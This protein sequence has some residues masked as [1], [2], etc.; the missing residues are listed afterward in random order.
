MS[1]SSL[2]SA[3]AQASF[4]TTLF[5]LL[6]PTPLLAIDLAGD[7]VQL[8]GFLTQGYMKSVEN[9]FLGDTMD[10]TFRLTEI[11]LNINARLT[12][13]FRLGG[14]AL[15]SHLPEE[16]KG[17]V[18]ADWLVADYHFADPF[19]VR[20]GKLKMPMGLFNMER[21]SDFL[22]PLIFLPQSIYDESLRDSWQAHWGGEMYG[23]L[24]LSKWGDIDYQL[25][26]GRIHY[27]DD[28]LGT[29]TAT[30]FVNRYN[31][32]NSL[33]LSTEDLN[34]ENN[35]V[36]GAALFFNPS[37]KGLRGALTLLALDEES[38][39]NEDQVSSLRVKSKFVASLEYSWKNFCW[40]GE[41]SETDR[42]QE[43]FHVTTVDGPSQAWYM[44]LSYSPLEAL[45]LSLLYDEYYR[46]KSSHHES[47]G[48]QNL[49]PWRKD[50]S[51]SL[52]YDI[53]ENWTFKAE[54]HTVD[55]TALYS[56]YFNPQG[57][58]RFWQYG[59]LRLSF[60]F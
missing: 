54:W 45:T 29:L 44:L 49:Y 41:Y 25:F 59:A 1:S 18:H 51:A 20:L 53:N 34:R 28:S 23:N 2:P 40:T 12:D 52:R 58:E 15:Y 9:N 37:L 3:R 31:K 56:G 43:Q 26:G 35:Y 39:L 21:D 17:K 32:Q 27:D 55:G 7:K 22:R 48:S 46:L 36:Y 13:K 60:N 14:Q 57:A 47:T 16:S 30:E 19:G 24:L 4:L 42:I 50:L 11:G 5:C 10:G 33:V 8:H 6:L 38:W